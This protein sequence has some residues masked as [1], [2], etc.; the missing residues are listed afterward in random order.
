MRHFKKNYLALFLALTAIAFTS[1]DEDTL[2]SF[3]EAEAAMSDKYMEAEAAL[4]NIYRIVDNTMR[5]S[6][7]R[8]TDSSSV[9]GAVVTRTANTILV[10]FRPGVIGQDGRTRSGTI[11]ITETNDYRQAGGVL[12]VDLSNY[13]ID[14][15]AVMGI[16]GLENFGSDSLRLNASRLAVVDSFELDGSKTIVWMNGFKTSTTADD[17]YKI[18]GMATG[19]QLNNTLTSSL[20]EPMVIDNTCQYR[21]LEGL[22]E[23][24]FFI[25]TASAQTT[26]S[27][28]FIKA[29]G[30]ENLARIKIKKGETEITL[31]RQFFG[32]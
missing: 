14:N 31:A 17:V 24:D 29:D 5:D 20:K 18:K 27:I 30:C 4:S 22:V 2:A 26:G 7:L 1:C 3:S 6:V 13:V 16:L 11:T 28:D 9:F 10:D 15:F 32:F 12:A 8:A 19:K 21:L 23:M 25:D